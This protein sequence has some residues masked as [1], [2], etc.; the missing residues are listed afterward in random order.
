MTWHF[1]FRDDRYLSVGCV[2]YDLLYFFL[3][4]ISSVSL[5]VK[6]MEHFFF[7]ADQGF[8][9]PGGHRLQER[10]FFYFDA[11]ALV[12]CQIPVEGFQFVYGQYINP[13]FP[14]PYL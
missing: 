5:T 10:I 2:L 7:M 6:P 9:P 3:R 8:L 11:P 4:I 1:Y 13:F 12:V 14:T